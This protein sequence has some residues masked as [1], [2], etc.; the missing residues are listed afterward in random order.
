MTSLPEA[1]FGQQRRNALGVSAL[2]TCKEKVLRRS[3]RRSR[4][5]RQT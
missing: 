5:D 3:Q 2:K 4:Q 1:V